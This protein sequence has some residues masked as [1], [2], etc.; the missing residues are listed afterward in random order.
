MS[1]AVLSSTRT[2]LE[3][4]GLSVADFLSQRASDAAYPTFAELVEAHQR[5]QPRNTSRTWS[6]HNRRVSRG[7]AS[8]CDCTCDACLDLTSG[9]SCACRRCRDTRLGSHLVHSGP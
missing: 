8:T 5:S 4:N 1:D 3:A 6:T 9:C 7:T 2:L